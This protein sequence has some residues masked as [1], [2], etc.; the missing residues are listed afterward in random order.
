MVDSGQIKEAEDKMNKAVHST[1]EEL[2]VIRTGRASPRLVEHLHVEYY[3]SKVPLN[4]IAGISVPEARQL[5]ISPYD[6]NALSHIEKAILASDLGINPS[7]DGTIIRLSF[8]PLTQ[9]RRKELIKV[10]RERAEEGRVAV[11]NVRRHAKDDM[12]RREKD[13]E[14]T[15]DDLRRMEKDLQ[16]VTDHFVAE[17]DEVLAA[18][19]REL[20]EV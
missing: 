12:E 10:A 7:N 5:V 14:M 15:E 20:L 17:I 4:Q 16:R 1:R 3:G 11:R 18:K 13:G 9:D 8:P 19:E 6:R 2:A